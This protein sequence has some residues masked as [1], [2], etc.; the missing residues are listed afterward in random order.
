[1]GNSAGP[2]IIKDSSLVLNLDA[3]NYKSYPS[4]QDTFVNNVSLLLDGE[5]LTD[6]SQNNFTVTNSSVTVSSAQVKYGNSSL[7][8]NGTTT[9]LSLNGQSAFS[10]GTGDFTIET[11]YYPS[12]TNT[13]DTIYDS[14]PLTTNS[15]SYF[16]LRRKNDA[17][18]SMLVNGIDVILGGTTTSTWQHI[19]LC[20]SSGVTK[21]FLNGTQVGSN[22]SDTNSYAITSGR[23]FIGAESYTP[24]NNSFTLTGYLDDFRVTKS[25]I[26]TAN[27]TPPTGPFRLPG[28]VIDLTKNKNI[29]T[30]VGSPTYST[31]N[32]GSISFTT[33]YVSSPSAAPYQLGANDFTF[34]SWIYLNAYPLASNGFY[35]AM[36][37]CKDQ[38]GSRGFNFSIT[39]SSSANT[40]L[41]FGGFSDNSTSQNAAPSFPFQ[42]NTWYHVAAS[43]IGNLLYIYVNGNLLNAGGT[44]FTTTIQ[45]TTSEVRIGAQVYSGG[46]NYYVN[47][48]IAI[49]KLYNGRGL[50]STEVYNNFVANRGRFGY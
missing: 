1:M 17:S 7:F 31:S 14:R 12:D 15:T 50:T 13:E 6:K 8:F 25:A 47:G 36:I 46:Y 39:G 37:M 19:A 44:S 21:L 16:T 49:M 40:A 28:Q 23:P 42:L 5:S 45:S 18:L 35:T 41:L 27:F 34:E 4:A 24:S 26:Y 3:S 10:F 9:Y 48:R 38:L 43:R 32:G 2:K 22:Y 20:R 33:S 11:W 29:G 30:F